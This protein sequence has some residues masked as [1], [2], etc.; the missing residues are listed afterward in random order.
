[1]MRSS[2]QLPPCL[3]QDC[4]FLCRLHSA[5]LCRPLEWGSSPYVTGTSSYFISSRPTALRCLPSALHV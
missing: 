2:A 1:M 3:Q 4:A 5:F